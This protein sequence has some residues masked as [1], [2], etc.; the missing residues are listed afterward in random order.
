MELTIDHTPELLSPPWPNLYPSGQSVP[1]LET[2]CV[3]DEVYD[4]V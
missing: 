4:A 1:L 3:D 2:T